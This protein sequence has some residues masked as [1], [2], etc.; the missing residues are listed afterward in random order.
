M[1]TYYF[2]TNK[3][4]IELARD[5]CVSLVKTYDKD[6]KIIV[7]DRLITVRSSRDLRRVWER[8]SMLRYAGKSFSNIKDIKSFACK[9]INLRNEKIDYK[10]Y[11]DKSASKMK[12]LGMR[13]SLDNPDVTFG[14]IVSDKAYHCILLKKERVKMKKIYRHPAELNYRLATLMINLS[15]VKEGD[16]LLDPCCGTGTIVMYASYMNTN[17]IGCDIS[18]KMCR[19]AKANLNANNLYGLIINSD[20]LY[21][22]V[23]RAD[24]MVSNMPYGRASSTYKRDSKELIRD[25]IS[26]YNM[27]RVIMCKEGD[28]PEYLKSYNLYVHSSLRRKIVV[29]R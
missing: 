11:I 16:I 17:A 5:E 7:K 22:P 13:V 21:M 6:V 29:C 25:I 4:N 14:I 18:M 24:A 15:G 2:I 27:T 26:A 23:K 8:A 19:Y 10:G 20:A 3:E 1:I 12:E 28:E 9:V